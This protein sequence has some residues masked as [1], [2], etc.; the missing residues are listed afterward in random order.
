MQ[1]SR[2][3]LLMTAEKWPKN[4][5]LSRENEAEI[6]H[7]PSLRHMLLR[8]LTRTRASRLGTG[9]GVKAYGLRCFAGTNRFSSLTAADCN[10]AS[11]TNRDDIVFASSKPGLKKHIH[12]LTV[13]RSSPCSPFLHVS[14]PYYFG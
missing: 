11:A 9:F 2:P 5:T 4:D 7:L 13:G 12:V 1:G 6:T 3:C 10:F 8:I 14:F